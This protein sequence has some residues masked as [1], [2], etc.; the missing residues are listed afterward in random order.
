[1]IIVNYSLLFAGRVARSED[2]NVKS[3]VAAKRLLSRKIPELWHL[4]A[5]GKWEEC[6][7]SFTRRFATESGATYLLYLSEGYASEQE[8]QIPPLA[9]GECVDEN[10]PQLT[11]L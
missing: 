11:F 9:T 1:M 7:G 2:L 8:D 6:A 4:T 3:I 5:I 10:S